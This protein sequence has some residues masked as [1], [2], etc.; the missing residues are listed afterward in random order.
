MNTCWKI[1]MLSKIKR[2]VS[3]NT[4][5]QLKIHQNWGRNMCEGSGVII[6]FNRIEKRKIKSLDI[7][8][9]VSINLD[10]DFLVW[11]LMS[12]LNREILISISWPSRQRFW[13]CRDFLDCRDL[14]F[15][16]FEIESLE[17]E[18]IKTNRDPRLRDPNLF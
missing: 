16:S 10:R 3:F 13:K 4:T 9:K 14:H 15:D 11:T 5:V 12:R 17:R 18:M 1:I 2:F 6:S 8:R 7:S